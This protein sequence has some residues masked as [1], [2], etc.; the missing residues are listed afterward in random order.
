MKV[1]KS[2]P[3]LVLIGKELTN[4][5]DLNSDW[6]SMTGRQRSGKRKTQND[7]HKQQKLWNR[8]RGKEIKNPNHYHLQKTGATTQWRSLFLNIISEQNSKAQLK[9]HSPKGL[10]CSVVPSTLAVCRSK[11]QFAFFHI[12]Q[13]LFT[14][15][16]HH[17]APAS[18][19]VSL[20]NWCHGRR[21]SHHL[22]PEAN[23][24]R[25]KKFRADRKGQPKNSGKQKK[26]DLSLS[27]IR[28]SKIFHSSL[29]WEKAEEF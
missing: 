26:M 12:L 20:C 6:R 27:S 16:P 25:N 19:V 1:T 24:S 18:N 15:H 5:S 14:D 3:K 23:N 17:L 29:G 13:W 8:K 4:L 28:C 10:H 9:K 7:Y 21:T 11:F 22:N 2:Y